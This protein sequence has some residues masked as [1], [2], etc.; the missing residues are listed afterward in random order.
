MS[1]FANPQ[2]IAASHADRWKENGQSRAKSF[3]KERDAIRFDGN[4]K[5]RL[6][7]GEDLTPR[8][9]QRLDAFTQQW[10]DTHMKV[11]LTSQTQDVYATQ[12]DLRI[13]PQLGHL[14][15]RDIRPS[16][17]DEFVAAMKRKEVGDPTIV[18]T[19]T[20]LQSILQRAVRDEEIAT[21]P[22]RLVRK[23]AQRREREPIMVSPEFRDSGRVGRRVEGGSAWLL[24]FV[25]A[26]ES[27][28]CDDMSGHG[29]E[30]IGE[31]ELVGQVELVVQ[32]EELE[33]VGMWPVR[34]RGLGAGPAAVAEGAFAVFEPADR[35]GVGEAVLGDAA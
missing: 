7:L 35:A 19:L 15:L 20:V 24:D 28:A 16:T 29:V 34:A 22:V 8:G 21:N 17:I 9:T 27:G 5:R 10:I 11:A 4:I 3:D 31:G 13:L 26:V 32:G 30:R 23:P 14:R 18:K 33:D 25:G 12:L 6:A 1:S 2:H